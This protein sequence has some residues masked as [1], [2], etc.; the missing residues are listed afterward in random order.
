MIKY[1]KRIRLESETYQATGL[2]CSI[3]IC[4][5]NGTGVFANKLFAGELLNLLKEHCSKNDIPLYAYCIMPDHVHL[6]INASQK[7]GIIGFVRGIKSLAT[8]MAW[9]YNHKG[10]I[11]QT[12]FYDHFLRQDED[13]RRVVDYIIQNPVRKGIVT[14]WKNYPFCGSLVYDL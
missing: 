3:T 1:H 12:S 4:T 10:S 13:L 7:K 8:R 2:P 6:L 5:K 9:K 14:E 11:W